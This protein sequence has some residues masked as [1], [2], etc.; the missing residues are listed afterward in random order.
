MTKALKI[1]PLFLFALVFSVT[2]D[3]FHIEEKLFSISAEE[4]EIEVEEQEDH[5]ASFGFTYEK[6]TSSNG[7]QEVIQH[8]QSEVTAEPITIHSATKETHLLYTKNEDENPSP[9][10]L[11][12]CTIKIPYC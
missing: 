5:I 4:T 3:S 8:D 7:G 6:T 9:L 10:Y 11:L 12:Y 1:V 2:L